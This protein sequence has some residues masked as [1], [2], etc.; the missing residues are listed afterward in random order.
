MV[1]Q[2]KRISEDLDSD[3]EVSPVTVREFLLWYGAERRGHNVVAKIRADLSEHGVVTVPDFEG[4]WIDGTISFE[5][6][7]KTAPKADTEKPA[8][9]GCTLETLDDGSAS[10]VPDDPEPIWV[11]HDPSHQISKLA[12]ANQGVTWVSP[13]DTLARATTIMLMH[14]FSQLPVMTNER[15][16]RGLVSWRSIAHHLS[17]NRGGTEARHA[18]IPAQEVR[19]DTSIFDVIGLVALH[20]YVLVRDTTNKIAGIVTAADLSQQ[21]R[22]LS[23]PFLLLSEIENHIRNIIGTKFTIAEL[24]TARD[25]ADSREIQ[26]VADLTFGEYLRL[27]ENQDRWGQLDLAIDRSYFCERLEFVRRVRNDVMHF[28]PDGI[29]SDQVRGLREFS[30]AL[31]VLLRD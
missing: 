6:S 9:E 4:S 7:V 8:S 21:F 15:N 16:L 27:I 10:K 14:D 19:H 3:E 24:S 12:S 20:D 2:V 11:E 22:N 18:M 30:R 17:L 29:K 28:D 13:N 1:E 31:R 23:E 26:G 5:K 25:P